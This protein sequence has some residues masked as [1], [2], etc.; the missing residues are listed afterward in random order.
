MPNQWNKY[1]LF[2]NNM[3]EVK[4]DFIKCRNCDLSFFYLIDLSLRFICFK[5]NKRMPPVRIELTTP[6][7]QDQCSNP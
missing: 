2:C 6:G 7:L 3:L 4:L 5:N 1:I